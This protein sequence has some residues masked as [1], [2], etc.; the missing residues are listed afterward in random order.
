MTMA[1]NKFKSLVRAVEWNVPSKEQKEILALMAKLESI[2][3]EK[4]TDKNERH[5]KKLD[6]K[7]EAPKVIM[8]TKERNGKKY[9]WCTKH[10]IW[11]LH[12]ASECT[13]EIT[14]DNYNREKEGNKL[15][16]KQALLAMEDD[17]ELV[18]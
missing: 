16:L 13:L 8:E 9:H 4:K 3:K 7:K 18:E 15:Q 12:K 11:T 10:K 6:S 1:E 17:E 5:K 14:K 2:T